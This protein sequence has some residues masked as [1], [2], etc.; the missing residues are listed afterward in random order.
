MGVWCLC[1]S[2]FRYAGLEIGVTGPPYLL[3]AV[4][5]LLLNLEL[6]AF[7]QGQ[8]LASPSNPA[9]TPS[10]GVTGRDGIILVYAC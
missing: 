3:F 8:Y 10:A 5:G 1:E 7:Q 6:V 9:A 4:E 2:V